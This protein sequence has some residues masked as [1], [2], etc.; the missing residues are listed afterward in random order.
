MRGTSLILL[1]FLWTGIFH[2]SRWA[3]S[4][5]KELPAVFR[6]QPQ[7]A[8]I[9]VTD[10]LGS[11]GLY[12]FHDGS[13]PF[14]AINLTEE[15]SEEK[16]LVESIRDQSVRSGEMFKVTRIAGKY[17]QVERSWLSASHRILLHIPLHPDRM[18]LLDWEALPGIGPKLAATIESDR[19]KNGDFGEFSALKRVKGIG[20]K[21]LEAWHTYFIRSNNQSDR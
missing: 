12:Q 8:T 11:Y 16:Q 14:C 13:N 2:Y 20:V 15:V 18:T 3:L 9:V 5:R 21:K 4:E 1:V 6:L 10:N 19:Q 17:I 7:L